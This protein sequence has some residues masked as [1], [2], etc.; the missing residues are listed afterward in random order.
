[1]LIGV[2]SI[3]FA[4][5]ID[6]VRF[7]IDPRMMPVQLRQLD[8][9]VEQVYGDGAYDSRSCYRA[10]HQCGARAIIP[11]R[12]GATLWEDEYLEDRNRNLRGVRKL[13]LKGWKSKSGYHKRSLVET[14]FFRLKT[15]FTDRFRSRRDDTQSTEAMIR[16]AALN[17]MT[18]IGMPDSYRV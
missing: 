1:M 11:P 6:A 13:G 2:M 14:A 18:Q 12:K 7:V 4:G 8:A 15:I 3:A 9:L 17:R 10:I 16:C 5:V